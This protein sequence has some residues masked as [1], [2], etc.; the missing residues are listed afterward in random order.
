MPVTDS[1]SAHGWA[2]PHPSP[3][4]C[5]NREFP[6]PTEGIFNQMADS[7]YWQ[8]IER[9]GRVRRYTAPRQYTPF[10][11][12]PTDEGLGFAIAALVGWTIAIEAGTNRLYNKHLATGVRTKRESRNHDALYRLKKLFRAASA[13]P[14]E[15]SWWP[16]ILDLYRLR[17]ELVQSHEAVL[18]GGALYAPILRLKVSEQ[19]LT[20]TRSAVGLALSTLAALYNEPLASIL[21]ESKN[22]P[23][24]KN[25]EAYQ[26]PSQMSLP[27]NASEEEDDIPY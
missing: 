4:A 1:R 19:L 9:A 24:L 14:L 10:H 15:M 13:A 2:D 20:N 11:G 5:M 18:L 7:H 27:H 3:P 21:G 23:T 6:F 17:Q 16:E 25:D 8:A 26:K 12:F 22:F